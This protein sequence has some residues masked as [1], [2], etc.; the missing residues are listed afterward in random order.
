MKG[1]TDEDVEKHNLLET[2][3]LMNMWTLENVWENNSNFNGPRN[4]KMC[5]L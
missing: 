2:P 3:S 1:I 5:F 4:D